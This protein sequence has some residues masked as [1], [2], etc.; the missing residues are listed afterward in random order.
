MANKPTSMYKLRL[1]LKHYHAGAS[2]RWLAGV[3]EISRS[4]LNVYWTRIEHLN[5]SCEEWEVLSDLEVSRLLINPLPAAPA[6]PRLAVLTAMLPQISK[7]LKKKGMTL[8]RQWKEYYAKHPNGYR[9]TGFFKHVNRYLEHHTG[10]MV[11]PHKYGD[12]L[13]V[14]YAGRTLPYA[15]TETGELI[16]CQIFVAILP[17]S[18]YVYVE[19]Q[20]S[21]K[22]EYFIEGIRNAM[23]YMGGVPQAIVPDNLKS[24]V[25]KAHRYEPTINPALASFAEHY[26]T[27]IMPTRV[28]KP[29]DKALVE[30]M[31]SIIYQEIYHDVNSANATSLEQ[32]N[33][34]IWERLE[35]LNEA[36][37]T[38]ACSRREEFLEH[39]RSTLMPLPLSDWEPITV[40]NVKVQRNGHIFLRDDNHH[41]SVPYTLIGK[42]LELVFS[43]SRVRLYYNQELIAE[44]VRNQH[45]GKYTTDLEHLASHHRVLLERSPQQY[46]DKAAEVGPC[47]RILFE[48]ILAKASHPEQGYKTCDG[49]LSLSK[50]FGA[51]E[52]ELSAKYAQQLDLVNYHIIHKALTEKHYLDQGEEPTSIVHRHVRGGSYYAQISKTTNPDINPHT[53]ESHE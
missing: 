51:R 25:I 24:A 30:G 53:F 31:V 23:R 42:N 1:L 4:T 3:L 35:V 29:R 9:R 33:L 20:P 45:R 52:L 14:D 13:F 18:Q 37:R 44:H 21:Q 38:Q 15:D 27:V 6:D 47:T 48:R 22:Q 5:L 10:Y 36:P 12:Q 28:R 19:A 8:M 39:E 41:Y 43:H 2:K 34:L 11:V 17:A 49:I 26:T 16:E 46:L 50:R 7:D 32:L 40:K